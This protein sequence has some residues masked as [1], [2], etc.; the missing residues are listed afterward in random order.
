MRKQEV[1]QLIADTLQVTQ[2]EAVRSLTAVVSA[3]EVVFQQD[4]PLILPGFGTLSVRQRAARSLP[5]L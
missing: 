5:G 3:F 1:V 4:S 2:A